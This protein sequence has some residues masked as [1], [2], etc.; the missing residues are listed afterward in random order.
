[1]NVYICIF[2]KIN[3]KMN[4]QQLAD[5]LKLLQAQYQEI[6]EFPN[7]ADKAIIE[8][9]LFA[10]GVAHGACMSNLKKDFEQAEFFLNECLKIK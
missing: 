3:K 10:C 7:G 6:K 8:N 9:C 5:E 4:E 2:V 1:V